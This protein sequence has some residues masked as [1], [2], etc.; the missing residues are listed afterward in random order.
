MLGQ[1]KF[2]TAVRKEPVILAITLDMSGDPLTI[3]PHLQWTARATGEG[4]LRRNTWFTQTVAPV[5][6]PIEDW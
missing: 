2:T 4:P 1:Q 6:V 5:L 3:E